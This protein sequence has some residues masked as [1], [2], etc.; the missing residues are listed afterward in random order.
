MINLPI[1]PALTYT[2]HG[3]LWARYDSETYTQAIRDNV[4]VSH[5][6][7]LVQDGTPTPGTGAFFDS[8]GVSD[9]YM[10]PPPYRELTRMNNIRQLREAPKKPFSRKCK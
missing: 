4:L 7:E 2:A 9:I 6:Y 5:G 3:V 10:V 8:I 1:H